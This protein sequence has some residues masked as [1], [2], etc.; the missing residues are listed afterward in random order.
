L[1]KFVSEGA[2]GY[3]ELEEAGHWER[4]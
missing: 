1:L 3:R 2:A 4:E